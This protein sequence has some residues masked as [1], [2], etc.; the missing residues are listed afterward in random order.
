MENIMLLR[1]LVFLLGIT[2]SLTSSAKMLIYNYTAIS[3]NPDNVGYTLNGTIGYNNEVADSHPS[4]YVGIYESAGYWTGTITGDGPLDG[5]GFNFSVATFSISNQDYHISP[6]ECHLCGP[7]TDL[8]IYADPTRDFDKSMF[9]AAF[10][11]SDYFNEQD[12]SIPILSMD[13]F[14]FVTYF[15]PFFTIHNTDLG[16]NVPSTHNFD[17]T[18]I[19]LVPVPPAIW[20]FSSAF[21]GIIMWSRKK[22]STDS[23]KYF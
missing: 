3:S 6:E 21:F 9:Y 18:S 10:V 16:L 7:W 14:E 20:L 2:V 15:P 4:P 19:T 12:D 11:F 5:H 17:V 13:L 23:F 1:S 22:R 8:I